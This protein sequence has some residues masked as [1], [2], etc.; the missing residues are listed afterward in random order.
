MGY[1]W[2][3]T[4]QHDARITAAYHEFTS[5]HDRTALTRAAA[6]LGVPRWMVSRRGIS[7]GLARAKE[8]PWGEEEIALLREWRHYSPGEISRRFRERGFTRSRLGIDVKRKR[9]RLT[10]HN[11]ENG[12]TANALAGLFNIDQHAISKWIHNGLLRAERRL[13]CRTARQGG[14]GYWIR[15]DDVRAFIFTFPEQIDLRKVDP[16]WFIE[17]LRE[18]CLAV[19]S[20]EE[21][22]L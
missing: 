19:P 12:Y 17:L 11:Q 1:K 14:D 4:P 2:T 18:G 3:F 22:Y 10:S 15:R 16:I 7:L 5:S 21:E 9:L 8:K 20:D 13:T 6:D